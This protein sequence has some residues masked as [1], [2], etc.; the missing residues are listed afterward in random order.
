VDTTDR[1]ERNTFHWTVGAWNASWDTNNYTWSEFVK[2]RIRHWVT[3]DSFASTHFDTLSWE[4]SPTVDGGT[5]QGKIKWYD[6]S[7]KFS[8][9]PTQRGTQVLPAET[10]TVMPD[11][12]TT[13]KV[14]TRN[15]L[16]KP[17]LEIESWAD[18]GGTR[19]YRTNSYTYSSDGIDLLQQRFDPS[20]VNRLVVGYGYDGSHPHLPVRITNAVNEITYRTYDTSHRVVT[21]TMPSGLVISNTYG[22]DGFVSKTVE[23][24]G[25]RPLRTNSFTYSNGLVQTHTDPRGLMVSNTWDYLR[26]L[27]RVDFPDSTYIAYAYTNGSGAMLLDKTYELD[28]LGHARR[29]EFDANSRMF[30][31][32]DEL[33]R[34]TAYLHSVTSGSKSLYWFGN[35]FYDVTDQRWLNRDPVG[36]SDGANLYTFVANSPVNRID[37]FGKTSTVTFSM[38]TDRSAYAYDGFVQAFMGQQ[39][40]TV[41]YILSLCGCMSGYHHMT[42]I[43]VTSSLNP[44]FGPMDGKF[45]RRPDNDE[46]V[47]YLRPYGRAG[48]VPTMLTQLEFDPKKRGVTLDR[49][50]IVLSMLRAAPTTLAHELG[51]AAQFL[52]CKFL[53]DQTEVGFWLSMLR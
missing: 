38:I 5:N 53:G 30:K 22:G 43:Y 46:I 10:S 11:G 33:D 24:D 9:D 17:T 31:S 14:T 1:S 25:S 2:A 34:I 50:G 19:R 32:H 27:T 35:R 8:G 44:S 45:Y 7:G 21:V 42:A 28:R 6:Y 26:R 18:S 16:G 37:P 15:T 47:E 41:S 39:V 51:G 52:F 23:F 20:G 48:K 3:D 12:T 49:V 13:Y 40:E 29:Y 36:E 4:Q